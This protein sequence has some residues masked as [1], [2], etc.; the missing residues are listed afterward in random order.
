[1]SDSESQSD[2]PPRKKTVRKSKHFKGKWQADWAQFRLK[3]SKKGKT[4]AI[5]TVCNCD[6]SVAGGG[7]HEVKRHRS[8]QKHEAGLR[9]VSQQQPLTALRIRRRLN[10]HSKTR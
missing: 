10:L 4:F 9:V 6:F 3:P 8:S 5:C 1:M 2:S 7:V